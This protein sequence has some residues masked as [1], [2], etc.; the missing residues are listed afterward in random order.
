M[1][2]P[3][4]PRIKERGQQTPGGGRYRAP[5][6]K[7]TRDGSG[8]G[9]RPPSGLSLP[10]AREVSDVAGGGRGSPLWVALC[11]VTRSG[12]ASALWPSVGKRRGGISAWQD[13]DLVKFPAWGAAAV[14]K[15]EAARQE[16]EEE[17]QKNK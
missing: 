7:D 16:V 13:L 5:L 14:R 10:E 3:G 12:R 4:Q 2:L 11:Q 8:G 15:A 9:S 17:K 6:L 1:T